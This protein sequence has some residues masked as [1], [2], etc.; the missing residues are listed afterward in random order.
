MRVNRPREPH[1]DPCQHGRRVYARRHDLN[2]A[3]FPYQNLGRLVLW[4]SHPSKKWLGYN[5]W[6][7]HRRN[8]NGLLRGATLCCDGPPSPVRPYFDR[9]RTE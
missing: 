1:G 4:T 7:L 5:G 2:A 8:P 3:R 6:R 9:R